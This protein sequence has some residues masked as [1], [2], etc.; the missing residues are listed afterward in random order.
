MDQAVL[1]Q[2][3]ETKP[4]RIEHLAPVQMKLAQQIAQLRHALDRL[5]FIII[6]QG[7]VQIQQNPILNPVLKNELALAGEVDI[8]DLNIRVQPRN[9]VLAGQRRAHGRTFARNR[10]RRPE[11]DGPNQ[12]DA[13]R[14]RAA[15]A[16]V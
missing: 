13:G 11:G 6:T 15:Q 3:R 4:R 1:D 8:N 10:R 5:R 7:L 9:I 2:L 14:S 16:A 12:A